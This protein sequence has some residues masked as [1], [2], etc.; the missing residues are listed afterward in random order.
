MMRLTVE[1]GLD[2]VMSVVL[3]PDADPEEIR[4]AATDALQATQNW[5]FRQGVRWQLKAL[6][7]FTQE[8]RD[9]F[10]NK[11]EK[12]AKEGGFWKM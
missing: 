11:Y 12:L 8:G 7:Q 3:N 1:E 5:G 10:I 2:K 9:R 4:T 6:T